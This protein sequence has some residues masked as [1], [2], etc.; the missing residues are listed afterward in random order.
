[1]TRTVLMEEPDPL[2]L[3]A[4]Y[5]ISVRD[6]GMRLRVT[7]DWARRLAHDHRHSGRVRRVVLEL[8]LERERLHAVCH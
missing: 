8:A 2:A 6:I 7:P 3:A 4:A 5:G 1:M